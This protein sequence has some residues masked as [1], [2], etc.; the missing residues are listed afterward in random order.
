MDK[1]PHY[2]KRT[3]E[4]NWRRCLL[5]WRFQKNKYGHKENTTFRKFYNHLKENTQPMTRKIRHSEH[6]TICSSL[7]AGV[8]PP[9]RKSEKIIECSECHIFFI[10]VLYF[11]ETRMCPDTFTNFFPV[12]AVD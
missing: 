5:T 11:T 8:S 7:A 3:W 12:A 1:I 9:T 4:R 2:E 10:C 6:S